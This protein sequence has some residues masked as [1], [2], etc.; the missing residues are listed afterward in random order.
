M[1]DN[2]C[3][4]CGECAYPEVDRCKLCDEEF[5]DS[6]VQDAN[7]WN[8]TCQHCG[9][10]EWYQACGKCGEELPVKMWQGEGD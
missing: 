4:Q 10:N 2:R 6:H 3:P 1:A 9:H 5:G 8:C 7:G